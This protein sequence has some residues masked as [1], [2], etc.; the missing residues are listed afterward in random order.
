M[1]P[2]KESFGNTSISKTQPQ[3]DVEQP[4]PAGCRTHH[5]TEAPGVISMGAGAHRPQA[6]G[7]SIAAWIA[8]EFGCNRT[9]T[10]PNSSGPGYW[11]FVGV[12]SVS[13]HS[14]MRWFFARHSTAR[15]PTRADLDD[16]VGDG[17]N[18][19]SSLHCLNR[20]AMTF[21]QQAASRLGG[22][23]S[24]SSACLPWRVNRRS[25]GYDLVRRTDTRSEK[26]RFAR[27]LLVCEF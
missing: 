9:R 3:A 14:S 19:G 4:L 7:Q 26:T 10:I 22:C 24:A 25:R 11:P 5:S 12:L 21:F 17:P 27:C 18:L 15:R 20:K 2:P 23:T 16:R 1:L 8:A 13:N 6:R